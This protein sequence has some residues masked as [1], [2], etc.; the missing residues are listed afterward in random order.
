M[1]ALLLVKKGVR[2]EH[3]CRTYSA[4]SNGPFQFGF[5]SRKKTVTRCLIAYHGKA[6]IRSHC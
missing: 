2:F 3:D 6:V 4:P 5:G 1:D